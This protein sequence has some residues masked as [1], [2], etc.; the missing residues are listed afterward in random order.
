MTPSPT[1]TMSENASTPQ[2]RYAFCPLCG[3]D[4][5]PLPPA[6]PD[7]GRPACPRGHFVHY[8]NPSPTVMGFVTD[9]AG[10]LLVLRRAREPFAGAWEL[11]GGF[12][13]A[14]ESAQEALAREIGEETGLA[15]TIGDL[16]GTYPSTYGDGGKPLLDLAFA[17]TADDVE[18]LTLSSE[19][20]QAQW[21]EPD[22]VPEPAFPGE[23]A[24]LA[25]WRRRR[26][27]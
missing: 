18:A 12:V 20:L 6:H 11:P 21:C 15:V 1:V 3:A 19:S 16:V 5:A 23:R 4:L 25:D 13:E 10:R 27:G 22:A 14:G 17:A 2:T 26:G 24:A 8:V 7:A 9:G